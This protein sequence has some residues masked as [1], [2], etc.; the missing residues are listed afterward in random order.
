MKSDTVTDF[1]IHKFIDSYF[2]EIKQ[3]L[4]SLD[5]KIISQAI[6]MIMQA[7]HT[8]NTIY[9]LGNGGSASTA[10]HIACDLGKGTLHRIYDIE[11]KRLHVL[12]LTEN[13]ALITAYAND[14]SYNDI[15]AKQL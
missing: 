9:I 4:D 6:D 8:D 2:A 3:S 7:Y 1:K 12:S 10:S 15:F 14:L 13:T 11:E 5:K